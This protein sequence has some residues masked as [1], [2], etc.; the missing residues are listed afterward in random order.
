MILVIDNYDSFTYNLVDYFYRLGEEVKVIRNTVLPSEINIHLYSG[1]VLSPGPETPEKANYLM[2]YINEFYAKIPILGICLGHQAINN[3]FGG[4]LKKGI[5]PMHGKVSLVYHSRRTDFFHEIPEEFKIVRYHSL[6]VDRLG[7]DLESICSSEDKTIMGIKHKKY[8]IYG[9]QF[10]PESILSE[11]G[12]KM[13]DNW[14][15]LS[16]KSF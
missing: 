8:N 1:L 16:R 4:T 12:L 2:E 15:K 14:L 9:V 10:H 11:Y 7:E 6:V 5:R 13:L 3:F